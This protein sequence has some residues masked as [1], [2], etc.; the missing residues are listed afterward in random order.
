MFGIPLFEER[1]GD[2]IYCMLALGLLQLLAPFIK[3]TE[4]EDKDIFDM[5][6]GM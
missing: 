5:L 6:S 4:K 2:G 3:K 1:A